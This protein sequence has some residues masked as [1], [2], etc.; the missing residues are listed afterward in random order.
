MKRTRKP[1]Y[2][3]EDCGAASSVEGV[4]LILPEETRSPVLVLV[5]TAEERPPFR[6]AQ[7]ARVCSGADFVEIIFQ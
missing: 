4:L 3:H 5:R 1:R 6:K 7:S 2:P